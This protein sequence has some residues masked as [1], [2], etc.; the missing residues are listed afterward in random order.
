MRIEAFLSLG[1]SSEKSDSSGAADGSGL[2]D[3]YLDKKR[4]ETYFV[5]RESP[6]TGDDSKVN[7][8][9]EQELDMQLGLIHEVNV[10]YASEDK[11]QEQ[12]QEHLITIPKSS[13][14]YS[15]SAPV[16]APRSSQPVYCQDI[17]PIL[18]GVELSLKRGELVLI[19]GPVG[20]GK[21]S[22]LSVILG[23]M[24]RCE[25]LLSLDATATPFGLPVEGSAA[26][27]PDH[28]SDMPSVFYKEAREPIS[29]SSSKSSISSRRVAYCAQRPWILA[30][31][32]RSNI[33]VAGKAV[34]LLFSSTLN[35]SSWQHTLSCLLFELLRSV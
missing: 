34:T 16:P 24:R 21:S 12:E 5:S 27:S 31:S 22:L 15:E 35:G 19:A 14:Y 7:L 20:A 11:E 8:S 25:Q 33:I 4:E 30:A 26:A 10:I 18:K 2:E 9:P 17:V 3:I 29:S 1:E 13:Y 6:T 32:V 28:E 23:E